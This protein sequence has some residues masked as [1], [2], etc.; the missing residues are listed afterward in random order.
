MR[1][2]S[3]LFSVFVSVFLLAGCCHD[4]MYQY[5]VTHLDGQVDTIAINDDNPR[6]TRWDYHELVCQCGNTT[7]AV[8]VKRFKALGPISPYYT[9]KNKEQSSLRAMTIA[10]IIGIVVML[11]ILIGGLTLIFK[12]QRMSNNST[13][14]NKSSTMKK[15]IV[16]IIYA[17]G[18]VLTF[19]VVWLLVK[20]LPTIIESYL[21]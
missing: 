10:S 21:K 11:S 20:Y 19:K 7:Y 1:K 4:N 13:V 15:I 3:Y 9:A 5:A 17:G 8:N 18:I 12:R 2:I 6:M 16:F 14:K